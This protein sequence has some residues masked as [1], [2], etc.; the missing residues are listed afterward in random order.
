MAQPLNPTTATRADYNNSYINE[1]P[2]LI[3]SGAHP[4]WKRMFD[5]TIALFKALAEDDAMAVNNTQTFNTPAAKKNAQYFAWDFVMRTAVSLFFFCLSGFYW[6]W[7]RED[8]RNPNP[9]PVH[10]TIHP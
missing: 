10:Q 9:N 1:L 7:F 2:T 8:G 4:M 6:M 5:A 3:G